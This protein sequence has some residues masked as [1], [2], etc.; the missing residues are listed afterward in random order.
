MV[1]NLRRVIRTA[2]IAVAAIFT[3]VTAPAQ[4]DSAPNTQLAW[5]RTDKYVAPD[6]EGYFPDDVEGGRRLD[7][8]RERKVATP[9]SPEDVLELVRRGLRRT[10]HHR[11]I[12][13]ADIGKGYVWNK[14]KQHPLAIE[15][16]YHAA[17]SSNGEVS[18]YALYHGPT[19]VSERTDN[20]VR[21]LMERYFATDHEIQGRIP[22]GFKTYGDAKDAVA[23]LKRLL[24]NDE[25]L[26]EEA[27]IATY[28]VYRQMTGEPPAETERLAKAGLWLI[29]FHERGIETHDG[30]RAVLERDLAATALVDFTSRLDGSNRVG[31]ALVRGITERERLRTLLKNRPGCTVDFD[32][33]FTSS[34]LYSLRL[35][36]FAKHLPKGHAEALP[37]ARAPRYEPS[38]SVYAWNRTDTYVPPDFENFFP[39]DAAAGA[40]LDQLYAGR[41][42]LDVTDRELLDQ[43]RRGLR[44]STIRPNLLVS[45]ITS[46]FQT[47][48]QDPAAIEL[49]YHTLDA[50]D[51]QSGNDSWRYCSIYFCFSNLQEKPNNVLRA[52]AQVYVTANRRDDM[53][54]RITWSLKTDREK[55]FFADR[56]LEEADKIEKLSESQALAIYDQ[57]REL[58]GSKPPRPER[59]EEVGTF[60]LWGRLQGS[61][62]AASDA[63]VEQWVADRIPKG[64]LLDSN[65]TFVSSKKAEPP[66]ITGPLADGQRAIILAVKGIAGRDAAVEALMQARDEF[67]LDMLIGI[68]QLP[69]VPDPQQV[70]KNLAVLLPTAFANEAEGDQ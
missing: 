33:L 11:T 63:E 48:P 42:K 18:H 32:Q 13:L 31:V 45:W 35:R 43:I 52:M 68:H 59:F 57:Y 29:G 14:E 55:K 1:A 41:E 54:G 19:V 17:G 62:L 34:S 23:R 9:G 5:Q 25:Q 4:E 40:A 38:R 49:L 47:W 65:V 60:V 24:D 7:E 58:T 66:L 2:T 20:L 51:Q 8:W 6:Y 67:T 46:I 37:L 39:N 27:L 61:L 26:S 44:R 3:P 69:D 10:K 53:G 30:L 22:W 56:L 16:L 36:E 64:R 28:E 70:R 15:L 50:P 21:M 12:I